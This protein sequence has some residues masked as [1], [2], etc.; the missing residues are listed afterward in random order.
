ML[1][2]LSVVVLLAALLPGEGRAEDWSTPE[3]LLPENPSRPFIACTAAELDR[4]RSAYKGEGPEHEIV[5]QV[6]AKADKT[7]DD[8]V[9]FPPRGG[10][11]NQ[12]YQCDKC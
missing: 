2:V 6:V 7:V 12:W 10:Q 11:H 4:L 9:V 3:V 1:C 8:P 5:A